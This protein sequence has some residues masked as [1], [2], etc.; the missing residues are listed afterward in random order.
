MTGSRGFFSDRFAPNPNACTQEISE[1]I[2]S[3]YDHPWPTYTQISAETRDRWFQK[4]VLKF[5]WDAEHNLII[6]K[7]YDH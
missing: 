5:I 4:W 7:I 1:V 6:R 2:K 3:M